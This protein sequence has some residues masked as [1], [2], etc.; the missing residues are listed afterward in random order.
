MN[1]EKGIIID[2]CAY[3]DCL[4]PAFIDELNDIL[5]NGRLTYDLNGIEDLGR[6]SLKGFR[7]MM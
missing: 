2:G 1:V 7:V 5:K 3:T 6:N 4:V